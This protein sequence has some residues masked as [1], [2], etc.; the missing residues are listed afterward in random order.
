MHCTYKG[1]FDVKLIICALD[2]AAIIYG[3]DLGRAAIIAT[4]IL[5]GKHMSFHQ[6][7]VSPNKSWTK[8]ENSALIK[9]RIYYSELTFS[10][11]S[12]I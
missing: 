7:D 11:S 5:V 9:N 1:V 2:S 10:N 3:Y 4:I 6:N 8:N 12:C